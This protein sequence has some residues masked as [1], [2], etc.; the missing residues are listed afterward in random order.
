LR[1][2]FFLPKMPCFSH[3]LTPH[4]SPR[5]RFQ[6]NWDKYALFQVYWPFYNMILFLLHVGALLTSPI[7]VECEQ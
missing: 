1:G 7:A 2:N 6:W 5:S 3:G 4:G